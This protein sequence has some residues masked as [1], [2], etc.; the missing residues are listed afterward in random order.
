MEYEV[1]EIE[2]RRLV[3]GLMFREVISCPDEDDGDG[4]IK[5]DTVD[6]CI[7]F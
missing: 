2:D 5:P 6:H 1:P 7:R 3:L 4:G